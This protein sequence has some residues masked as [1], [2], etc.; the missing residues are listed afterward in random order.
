MR[1]FIQRFSDQVTGILSGFDRLVFRG[2][3]RLLTGV[4]GM[5]HF[6]SLQGIR[7]TEFREYVLDIS[8]QLKS[9]SIREA[10][11]IGRPVI[12]LTSAKENKEEIALKIAQEDKIQ[13]G[14]ITVLKSLELC[15][16]YTIY[17]DKSTKQIDLAKQIRKCL[18]F[19]HYYFHSEFG[20]INARIQTWI[21]FDIQICINGREWLSRK[22]DK[23]SIGYRR[24]D[25]CFTWIEDPK[26]A[27]TLMENQLKLD[28]VRTFTHIARQLNPAHCQIFRKI[29]LE[30]YWTVY[31]SEW[32]TDL[33]FKSS[34][35]IGPLHSQLAHYGITH[36]SSSDV[37]RFLGRRVSPAFK[38]EIISSFK[39]RPEGIRIK[40]YAGYNSVKL[41]DKAGSVLRVETT[42][43]TPY[44]L[45]VYR[46]KE[47]DPSGECAWRPLRKGIADLYRRAQYSQACN[48]RYLDA[49]VEFELNA[50]LGE[51]LRDLS[52][53]QK[54]KGRTARGL[55]PWENPEDFLLLKSISRGEFKIS[56]FRNKNL[57]EIFFKDSVVDPKEKR[58]RSSKVS[59]LIRILRA[60]GLVRK[61]ASAYR[62]T[63]TTRGTQVLNT[64]FSLDQLT[65]NQLQQAIA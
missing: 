19:Y 16:T 17:R 30:Y 51:L 36:F 2:R 65:L 9:S 3:L 44:D 11:K 62:Y 4:R 24:T 31:Q 8:D 28:W 57:Q 32:A 7:L 23:A 41:Y 42:I 1:R 13:S 46:P 22:L 40:H 45:K 61:I 12:Y 34:R 48:E 58:R 63:L 47:N 5:A 25:N 64:L 56:G 18:Y 21:P 33:M 37:M 59:R 6:L 10:E 43:N 54:W 53:R 50:S 39:D 55:R 26:R 14:L 35:Q 29:P 60:H 20:L 49:F 52:K 27:Q 15:K 38:G